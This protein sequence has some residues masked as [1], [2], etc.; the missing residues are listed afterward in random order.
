MLHGLYFIPFTLIKL[1]KLP[2]P[3]YLFLALLYFL[4]KQLFSPFL[5]YFCSCFFSQMSLSP[6]MCFVLIKRWSCPLLDV[7][8]FVF[9]SSVPSPLGTGSTHR[10]PFF[11][12]CLVKKGEELQSRHQKNWL[13]LC[14]QAARGRSVC[15]LAFV[16][17]RSGHGD[18]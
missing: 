6:T 12:L 11:L 13:S 18:L 3:F 5:V 17:S 8:P 4:F 15:A 16:W 14:N 7:Y 2:Y 1:I 10:M 9:A